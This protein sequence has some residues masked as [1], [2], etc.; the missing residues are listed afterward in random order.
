MKRL[1]RIGNYIVFI[2]TLL[3][4]FMLWYEYNFTNTFPTDDSAESGVLLTSLPFVLSF[5]Y[6]YRSH[7]A[8]SKKANLENFKKFT[9]IGFAILV[10]LTIL[11]Y[12]TWIFLNSELFGPLGGWGGIFGSVIVAIYPFQLLG[13]TLFIWNNKLVEGRWV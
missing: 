10:L 5:W 8:L 11:F 13:L 7:P 4:L 6:A 2:L 12:A 9:F 3:S 1:L